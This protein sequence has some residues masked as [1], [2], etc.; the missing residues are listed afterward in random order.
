MGEYRKGLADLEVG[1]HKNELESGQD[2]ERRK[3]TSKRREAPVRDVN[4]RVAWEDGKEYAE[5]YNA[6]ANAGQEAGVRPAG[7]E[8]DLLCLLASMPF[9]DRL[10][11]VA[12]SGCHRRG[13]W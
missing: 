9:V 3:Q 12:V 10:E 8:A 11:M 4:D 13:C 5:G 1:R 6:V 7:C 2:L